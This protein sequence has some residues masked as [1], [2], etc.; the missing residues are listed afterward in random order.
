M[1]RVDVTALGDVLIRLKEETL[2]LRDEII[3]HHDLLNN[4][5]TPALTELLSKIQLIASKVNKPSPLKSG[6]RGRR[7]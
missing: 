3:A 4:K 5:G 7:R 1:A 6:S 2:A